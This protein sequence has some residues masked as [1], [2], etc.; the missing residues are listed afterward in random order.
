MLSEKDIENKTAT[1]SQC[2]ADTP[3]RYHKTRNRWRCFNKWQAEKKRTYE[4]TK[5]ISVDRARRLKSRY[6]LSVETYLALWAAQGGACAICRETSDEPTGPQWHVDHDH[7]CCAG[8]TTCGACVRGILC[9][10]C[11]TGIGGLKD[12]RENL[13]RAVAYLDLTCVL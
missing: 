1:C 10:G 2:G 12:D 7:R 6:G 11:N 4:N 5:D 3:I 8:K 9:S 13:L